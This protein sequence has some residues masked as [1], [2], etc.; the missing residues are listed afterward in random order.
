MGTEPLYAAPPPSTPLH[1][2]PR[3]STSLYAAPPPFPP[4]HPPP[5]RSTLLHFFS[6]T[7]PLPLHFFT[8]KFFQFLRYFKGGLP[9]HAA[10]HPLHMPSTSPPFTPPLTP[11]LTLSPILPLNLD[12]HSDTDN[13]LDAYF[14]C[15]A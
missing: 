7:P 14:T 4:L 10:P 1:T 8:V 9:L 12:K 15:Y 2:P 13:L 11:P 3:R 6:T 5:R